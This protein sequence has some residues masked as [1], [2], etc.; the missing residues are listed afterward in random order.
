MGDRSYARVKIGGSIAPTALTRL[1][2]AF[3]EEGVE[4]GIVQYRPAGTVYRPDA[5]RLRPSGHR[6]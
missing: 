3:A 4:E 6:V 1:A 5:R 2:A